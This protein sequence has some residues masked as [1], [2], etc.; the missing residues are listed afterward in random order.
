MI[1]EELIEELKKLEPEKALELICLAATRA[2]P[3]MEWH[4]EGYRIPSLKGMPMTVTYS[5][6]DEQ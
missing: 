6:G 1:E 4:I 3:E 2:F 5:K